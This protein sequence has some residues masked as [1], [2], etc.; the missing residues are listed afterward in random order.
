M[1][2]A[3]RCVFITGGTGYMGQRLIPL[4]LARGHMVRALARAGSEK[5]VTSGCTAIVGDALDASSYADQVSP[6]DT[7]VQLVGV[8]H[9]S[10]SKAKQFREVDLPAGLGAIA[11]ARSSGINHL[12]YLSVAQPAPMMKAY[13]AVRAECEQKIRESG[14][15][16]TVLR[17]W[18]VLGPGHRWPYVLVPAYW[19]LEHVPFTREGARRLGLITLEQMLSALVNAIENPPEGVRVLGVPE[20][21]EQR[22]NTT[23]A[24]AAHPV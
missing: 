15:N 17:P 5:R 19:L 2:A 21:R 20:L 14:M 8:A 7:F 4:L 11:A 3:S 10:P 1:S 22:M 16:A 18:Y 24:Q 23:A 13:M 9:P 6:A 12:V